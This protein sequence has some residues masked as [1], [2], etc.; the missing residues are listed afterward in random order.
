MIKEFVDFAQEIFPSISPYTADAAKRA[1]DNYEKYYTSNKL[2]INSLDSTIQYQG[3]IFTE[4][5]YHR[6][7]NKGEMFITK[8][9][10]QLISNTCDSAR[11]ENLL[12]APLL[13]ISEV[14][15]KLLPGICKNK[16]YN[17]FYI[18]DS[19]LS[20]YIID[21][22]LI[23]SFPRLI[24][25]NLLNSNKT[26]RVASLS[27]VGYYMFIVKLSIFLLRPEDPEANNSRGLA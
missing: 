16:S 8:T 26:Q 24:F 27:D 6:I 11:E 10:V 9:K 22:S 5:P 19:I 21:F 15:K 14:D 20:D 1:L 23:F 12:F 17:L 13:P 7:N 3:D 18:P 25:V 2:T 4:L